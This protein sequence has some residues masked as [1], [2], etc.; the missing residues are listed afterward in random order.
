MKISDR[1][2]LL[3]WKQRIKGKKKLVLLSCILF[4]F[5]GPAFVVSAQSIEKSS[6]GQQVQ[7]APQIIENL[8][9][10][11]SNSRNSQ[12]KKRWQNLDL[13]RKKTYQDVAVLADLMELDQKELFQK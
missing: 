12:L 10:K 4:F 9:Q 2:D 3:Q 6:P 5:C 1:N 8:R 11:I 7:I 13:T